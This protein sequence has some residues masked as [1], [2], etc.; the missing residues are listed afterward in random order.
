MFAKIPFPFVFLPTKFLNNDFL[1]LIFIGNPTVIEKILGYLNPKSLGNVQQV[2]KSWNVA[3]QE[4]RFWYQQLKQQV[5]AYLTKV[6]FL[7]Y[8]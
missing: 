2:C 4:G 5:S 3:V 6:V 8:R 7:K 1:S